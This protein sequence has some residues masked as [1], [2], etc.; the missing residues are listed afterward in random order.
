MLEEIERREEK[1]ERSRSNRWP[2]DRKWMMRF[3]G[4]TASSGYRS[5]EHASV[6]ILSR[7]EPE[8]PMFSE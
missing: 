4:Q 7:P 2:F 1:R 3:L 8:I 6:E 5:V